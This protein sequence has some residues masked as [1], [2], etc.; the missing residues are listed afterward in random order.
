L[1]KRSSPLARVVVELADRPHLRERGLM[2]RDRLDDGHGMAFVF[3][4]PARHS[5][6]GLNTLIPL[7]VAFVNDSNKIVSVGRVK[8]HD[9]TSVAPEVPCVMAVELPDG[10]LSGNGFRV[11]DEC[12]LSSDDSPPC[13]IFR[14][15]V[16]TAQ[17]GAVEPQV[18]DG[19]DIVDG[20]DS[21]ELSDSFDPPPPQAETPPQVRADIS[22]DPARSGADSSVSTLPVP[23][24]E[25]LGGA[26][27]WA[28]SNRQS[29]TVEYINE[30]GERRVHEIEPH[31][32]RFSEK[33]R[34]QVISAWDTGVGAP[35]NFLLTNIVSYSFP[36]RTFTKKFVVS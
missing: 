12:H 20:G 24:F 5:F 16:K 13:C 35:R 31:E 30:K 10:W 2:F 17:S 18:L 11:G 22:V 6:W 28:V 14:R 27:G 21:V 7:D 23:K 26:V 29:M 8:A 25:G 9:M 33:S 15:V 4:R 3:D 36:G 32:M 34:R 19:V 1:P